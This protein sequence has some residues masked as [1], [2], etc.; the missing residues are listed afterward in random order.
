M[1]EAAKRDTARTCRPCVVM[2]LAL[3]LIL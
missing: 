2:T 3:P 1:D